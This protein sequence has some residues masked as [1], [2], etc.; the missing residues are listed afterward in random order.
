MLNNQ[1]SILSLANGMNVTEPDKA[2]WQ[3]AMVPLYEKWQ[4][5]LVKI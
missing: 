3:K 2:E 4:D 1:K 5:K